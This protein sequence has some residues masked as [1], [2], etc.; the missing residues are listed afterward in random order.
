MGVI[1]DLEEHCHPTAT[2][3][4]WGGVNWERGSPFLVILVPSSLSLNATVSASCGGDLGG[5][6][7]LWV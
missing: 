3:F 7:S 1:V 4:D 5:I 6:A 2:I